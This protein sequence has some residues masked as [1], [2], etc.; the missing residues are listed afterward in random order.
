MAT[1]EQDIDRFAR[2]AKERIASGRAKLS[3]D[4]LFDQ[5]RIQHPPEED[6]L[7]IQ[8]SLRDIERGETGRPFGEFAREFRKRNDIPDAE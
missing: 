7:A 6:T 2:F 5:W 8:A 1:T 3:I 4:E